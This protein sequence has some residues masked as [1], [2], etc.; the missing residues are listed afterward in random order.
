MS[1]LVSKGIKVSVTGQGSFAVSDEKVV[2]E[3]EGKASL[4]Q[5]KCMQWIS[6]VKIHL[7]ALV[8]GRS[9][10]PCHCF[11]IPVNCH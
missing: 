3:G 7:P 10:L 6:P 1:S 2:E 4:L 9:A 11:R 8:E 5:E